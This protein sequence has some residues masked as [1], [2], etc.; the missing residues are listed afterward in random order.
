LRAQQRSGSGGGDSARFARYFAGSSTIAATSSDR[1]EIKRALSDQTSTTEREVLHLNMS[2]GCFCGCS[3]SS[4]A[5]LAI[6]QEAQKSAATSSDRFEIKGRFS[7]FYY[8]DTP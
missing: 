2:F 4:L 3:N 7:P 1:F 6:L 5:S 8:F